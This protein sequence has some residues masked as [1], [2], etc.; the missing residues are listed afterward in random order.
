MPDQDSTK[1]DPTDRRRTVS[2]SYR[3]ALER[4]IEAQ[5]AR[6]AAQGGGGCCG[7]SKKAAPA[8]NAARLVDYEANAADVPQEALAG[9]FG[10]GNPL[11]FAEVRPGETVVDLG[12]GAGLDLLIAAKHVGPEGR[13][14]GV[15]MTDEMLAEARR[16][17]ERAGVDN[18]E[19]KKGVI[20]EL[21]LEDS[22]V[23]WVISN[24]VIN[25]STDKPAVFRELARVLKPG[26]RVSISD[27]VAEDLPD[28]LRTH[29]RTHSACIGGAISE[30]D[31]LA[32]LRAAGLEDVSVTERLVYERDQLV[33]VS[34]I[35]E[36][37]VLD[38]AATLARLHDAV[39]ACE[40]K[41]WSAKFTARKPA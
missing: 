26:G 2:E 8:G 40:G 32:G 17:V 5:G 33:G 9:S 14:I 16:N 36:G 19:L 27:I 37:D 6:E 18:V 31:Y 13:V 30:A 20:E 29:A 34:S 39:L 4:A 3:A 12:S 10:C 1:L 25:L 21:P 24:C 22:S 35:D 41:I 11:A 7:A 15:D 28:L 23:D 38:D